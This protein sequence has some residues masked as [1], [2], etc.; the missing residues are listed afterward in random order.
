M[1][2]AV[3]RAKSR[4]T[5]VTGEDVFTGNNSHIAALV[6]YI[7]YYGQDEHVHKAP[8]VSAF[9]LL[10]QEYDQSLER[11][12][13]R[14]RPADSQYKSEQIVAY[15][16][17]QALSDARYNGLV[18][19]DQVLLH[20]VASSAGL[21]LTAREK[22]FMAN[23]ASCDFVLYFEVGKRPFGVIEVDGGSHD[24][25]EQAERDALKDKILEKSKLPIL[26]LRTVESGIEERIERF[27]AASVVGAPR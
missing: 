24:E 26:R 9:D 8:V 14:L 1:N 6:R 3:S 12:N 22:E 13:A 21:E 7:E 23:G 16:L 10:Y 18:Y 20:Q 11:L 5:L 19:H 2:V 25:P 27:I 15:L 17:R 4:F